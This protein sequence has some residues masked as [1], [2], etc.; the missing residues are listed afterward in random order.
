MKTEKG[1]I[2]L[3]SRWDNLK[4]DLKRTRGHFSSFLM[5]RIRWHLYP[6]LH[7]VSK[8]PDHI[9]I[10]IS[11]ACN[12]RCPMCYTVTDEFKEKINVGLMEFKLYTKLIDECKKFKPYSI[13]LSFRGES[14]IHPQVYDMIKYAK[15]AGIKEVSS[16][17]HG[18]M[19]DEEKY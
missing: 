5:N 13:R 7:H 3:S 10:E 18:G 1:Q 19:L 2:R 11:S 12:L 14:F 16:L 17:T 15:D 4:F 8:F 9:D 6:R